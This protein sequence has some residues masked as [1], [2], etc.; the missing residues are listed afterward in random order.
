MLIIVDR[1]AFDDETRKLGLEF[2]LS[3]AETAG[4]LVRKL[5]ALVE[6][7][8]SLVLRFMSSV[9]DEDDWLQH[10]DDPNSAFGD[11]EEET[12]ELVSAGV[13]GVQRLATAIRGKLFLPIFFN[14][15]H[16]PRLSRSARWQDRRAALL[17]FGF[18]QPGCKREIAPELGGAVAQVLPFLDDPHQRV[19]HAA[20][21]C[22][23]YMCLEYQ[24]PDEV[25]GDSD[26]LQADSFVAEAR[27][28]HAPGGGVVAG[29]LSGVD[30]TGGHAPV[31]ARLL[32]VDAALDFVHPGV[33]GIRNRLG[34]RRAGS[35]KDQ[36]G[37]DHA[38]G[39]GLLNIHIRRSFIWLMTVFHQSMI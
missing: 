17:A 19:R 37:G 33:A 7:T 31:D 32:P 29:G 39:E 28:K 9:E 34:E 10:D 11:S 21:R 8:L 5:P 1:D 24:D 26:G 35:G 3:L 20:V 18:M 30:L 15:N 36:A 14:A 38:S 6:Q 25:A 2:L 23:G 4:S 13:D 16:W 22:L 27:K 12:T